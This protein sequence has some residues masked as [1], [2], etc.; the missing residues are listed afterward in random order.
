MMRDVNFT[1]C[2]WELRCYQINHRNT[3]LV[4]MTLDLDGP[5]IA[6][7]AGR[8]VISITYWSTGHGY[9]RS[10][11]SHTGCLLFDATHG[12]L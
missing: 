6:A 3:T 7:G 11:W 2:S 8:S 4:V 12:G 9:L 5:I 1:D 10:V